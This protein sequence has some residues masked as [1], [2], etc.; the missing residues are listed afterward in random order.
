MSLLQ[1]DKQ[2]LWIVIPARQ[3]SVGFPN[4]N[5]LLFQYTALQIPDYLKSRTIVSTD[6][7]V[8]KTSAAD[9][10]F[11]VV[12]RPPELA[13]ST[14]N[15]RDVLS[16]VKNTLS[17]KDDDTMIML[18]LT[19]P[20]RHFKDV[21]EVYEFHKR[22]NSLSTL[23]KSKVDKHPYLC[24]YEKNNHNGEQVVSHDLYRR[25][26]YPACFFVL[27]YVFIAVAS[28]IDNLNKNLYNNQTFYY[29]IERKIDIDD[30]EHFESW[31]NKKF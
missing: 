11:I 31:K 5:R 3:G 2:N 17:I 20:E 23:C 19:F 9:L 27:H 13:T 25:Q 4:K 21:V 10:G 1:K 29:P 24:L 14:A 26:D 22:N 15:T 30:P 16:H 8:L 12:D 18:Y 6:D 7:E 28:E